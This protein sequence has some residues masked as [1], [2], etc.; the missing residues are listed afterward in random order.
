LR[1]AATEE[2]ASE[3]ADLELAQSE[4]DRFY[5][6]PDAVRAAVH[7]GEYEIAGTCQQV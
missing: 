2:A 4:V 1:R 6:L 7:L 5:A 3:L